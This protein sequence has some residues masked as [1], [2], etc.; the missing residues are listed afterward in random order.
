MPAPDIIDDAKD[1]VKKAAKKASELYDKLPSPKDFMQGVSEAKGGLQAMRDMQ[2]SNPAI[3]P[4][5]PYDMAAELN[6][7]IARAKGYYRGYV[8]PKIEQAWRDLQKR[9]PEAVR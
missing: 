7:T 9:L 6:A 2:G 4:P 3:A 5:T 1:V 8:Q